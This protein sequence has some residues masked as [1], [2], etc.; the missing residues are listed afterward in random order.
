MAPRCEVLDPANELPK[1]LKRRGESSPPFLAVCRQFALLEACIAQFPHWFESQTGILHAR[2]REAMRCS[3]TGRTRP[4][5]GYP[6]PR[7][8][9]APWRRSEQR[10]EVPVWGKGGEGASSSE[11][12]PEARACR[13]RILQKA[14][15]S[16]RHWNAQWP[17]TR[18]SGRRGPP[19][20]GHK[21]RGGI[22]GNYGT[23]H[24]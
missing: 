12:P 16:H 11:I 18:T 17:R 6:I 9:W 8:Q 24:G 21:L 5:R 4:R 20:N 10:L 19:G 3:R 14:N 13:D 7:N 2:A 23:G 22:P 1:Q 15:Y